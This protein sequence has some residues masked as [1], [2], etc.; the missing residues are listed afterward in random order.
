MRNSLLALI[1]VGLTNHVSAQLPTI[2]SPTILPNNPAGNSLI[3]IVTHVQTP[4]SAFLVDKQVTVA[5]GSQSVTL[6][7]CYAYGMMSVVSDYID[8]FEVGQLSNGIHTV[9]LNAY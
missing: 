5:T 2:L 1:L 8:T 3:K 4:N 7:L 9:Q 6:H